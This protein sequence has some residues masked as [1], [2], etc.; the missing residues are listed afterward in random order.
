[1]EERM[2]TTSTGQDPLLMELTDIKRL[3]VFF[4]LKS[5]VSQ[6]EIANALDISQPTVSRMFKVPVK[7][8]NT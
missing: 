3:L 7:P 4:L 8:W 6:T 5:G 1:M 2:D